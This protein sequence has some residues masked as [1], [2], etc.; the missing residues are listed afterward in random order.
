MNTHEVERRKVRTEWKYALLLLALSCLV[1]LGLAE[2]LVRVFFPISDGRDN[3]SLDGK[4]VKGWFDPGT[5]YRQV[6]NEYDAVT[7]ITEKGHRVP[8]PEGNPEVIFLGDSFTYGYGLKDDETFASIYCKRMNRACANLGMPGSGT[9]KQV[10]RLD[11]FLQTWGWKPR[12]VKL[13]FFGMSGS[14]SAGNDFVDNYDR[15]VREHAGQ[16]EAGSAQTQALT[17]QRSVGFA[18]R[19]IGWQKALLEH[20]MLMRLAKYYWGPVLKS[21]IVADVGEERM[22][23]AKAATRES[24]AKLDE[25]SRRVGFTYTIYLFVPVQD[26]MRD[27]H[28]ETLET[29]NRLSP[30]PVVATAQLFLDT[31][32]HYYYAFDGHFNAEGSRRIAEFLIEH[33]GNSEGVSR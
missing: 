24:L 18:E 25:L 31:P 32:Q 12:E 19:L 21:L 9:L 28:S 5:V 1:S 29:L 26:I 16:Q 23:I 15:Y 14:F 20:S 2:G 11:E 10:E 33:D 3:V 7:T 13:F 30:K 4:P 22:A 6:S 27:T 17:E 8:G